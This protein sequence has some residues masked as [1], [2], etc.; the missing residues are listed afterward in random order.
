[1]AQYSRNLGS[2]GETTAGTHMAK[3]AARTAN[4]FLLFPFSSFLPKQVLP[5][6]PTVP[7]LSEAM[8]V[9]AQGAAPARY[10]LVAPHETAG[11]GSGEFSALREI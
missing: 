2:L 9:V 10:A 7:R 3:F 1:M 8:I 5:I 11:R 4:K 6:L